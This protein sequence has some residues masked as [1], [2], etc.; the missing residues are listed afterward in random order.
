LHLLSE[1]TNNEYVGEAI[2]RTF[3]RLIG[4]APSTIHLKD[5][6]RLT[7]ISTPPARWNVTGTIA[8]GTRLGKKKSVSSGGKPPS[9]GR[10]ELAGTGSGFFITKAGHILTNHHVIN[11]CSSIKIEK[12]GV[13]FDAGGERSGSRNLYSS[14]LQE[15]YFNKSSTTEYSN[16]ID[17]ILKKS[18]VIE[19]GAEGFTSTKTKKR[20]VKLIREGRKHYQSLEEDNKLRCHSCGFTKPDSVEREIVQL[21]HTEMISDLDKNGKQMDLEDAIKMLIP[22]CPTCHQ[23]AHTSKPPL[24]VD[25]IK[26]L[27]NID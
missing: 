17:S 10:N 20:S 6:N 14:Y 24:S 13:V 22:L 11:E 1:T 18:I 8:S 23:I 16:N 9:S 2:F 15:S 3:T 25:V 19:E 5:R 27:R 4:W 12:R 7:R 21:H 26:K